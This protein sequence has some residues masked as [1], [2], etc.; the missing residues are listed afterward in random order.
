MGKER[1]VD[2]MKRFEFDSDRKRMSAIIK[3]DG[4]YKVYIK[5]ADSIIKARLKKDSQ[6]YQA[7]I[8]QKLTD[9]SNIGLRTLMM[10][11][12]VLSDAEY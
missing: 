8:D 6:P 10:A 5:G 2:F 11:M 9:F 12:K 7:Y 4:V 1:K 3:D